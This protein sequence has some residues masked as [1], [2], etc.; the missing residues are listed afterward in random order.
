MEMVK[1]RPEGQFFDAT[2]QAEEGNEY[3]TEVVLPDEEELLKDKRRPYVLRLADVAYAVAIQN[4]RH[5]GT[6]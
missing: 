1:Q 2:Q 6:S 5:D 4:F 3:Q